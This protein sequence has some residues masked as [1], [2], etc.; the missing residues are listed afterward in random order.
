MP[1]PSRPRIE[2]Y[3]P[4][5]EADSNEGGGGGIFSKLPPWAWWA[6]GAMIGIVLI[7][8]V[9][10]KGL[11]Q[12]ATAGATTPNSTGS[13]TSGGSS[14][15]TATNPSGDPMPSVPIL[16]SGIGPPIKHPGLSGGIP[17]VISN[18]PTFTPTPMPSVP[19][20][21]GRPTL[22]PGIG[23]GAP[24]GVRPVITSFGSGGIR[25]IPPVIT[26]VGIP[27][28][29]NP[30]PVNQQSRTGNTYSAGTVAAAAHEQGSNAPIPKRGVSPVKSS[31]IT[32]PTPGVS[33]GGRFIGGHGSQ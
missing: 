17:P 1:Q 22:N 11:F 24:A 28:I 13:N 6:I 19:L 2:R 21:T 20:T 23:G 16:P 9:S 12:G 25:S 29:T 10:G 5:S 15:G 30:Q 7:L 32:T 26:S 3:P 8:W 18:T 4:V 33:G 14:G 27:T 31:P